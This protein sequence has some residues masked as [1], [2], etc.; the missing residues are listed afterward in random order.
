MTHLFVHLKRLYLF[1]A[2]L[3]SSFASGKAAD[4]FVILEEYR[5]TASA[6]QRIARVGPVSTGCRGGKIEG[7]VSI[8]GKVFLV[9]YVDCKLHKP[10]LHYLPGEHIEYWFFHELLHIKSD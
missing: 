10:G 8:K 3:V 9:K 1:V 2:V 4:N 6:T 7:A 5:Y